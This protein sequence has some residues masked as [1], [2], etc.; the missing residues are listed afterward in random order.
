MF[1][2]P[3][4]SD[5]GSLLAPVLQPWTPSQDSLH[6]PH[7]GQENK[8]YRI[9]FQGRYSVSSHISI[10]HIIIFQLLGVTTDKDTARLDLLL[11]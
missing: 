2:F 4:T 6:I 11:L 8:E 5:A 9:S 10:A 7:A 1:T 3:L